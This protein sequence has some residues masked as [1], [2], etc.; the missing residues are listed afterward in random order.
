MAAAHYESSFAP[1]LPITK[2]HIALLADLSS[3]RIQQGPDAA[4]AKV[5]EIQVIIKEGDQLFQRRR[6]QP[7]LDSFKQARA[8]IY[9]MLYPGFNS[10]AYVFNNKDVLLPV[11]AATEK[12][13]MQLS[14]RM[15]DAVRPTAGLS[16]PDWQVQAEAAPDTLK[17]FFSTGFREAVSSDEILQNANA[18]AIGLFAESKPELALEVLQAA[19][20]R[21]EAD[22]QV[23]PSLAAA[24]RLN[25]AAAHLQ[26]D[27]PREAAAQAEAAARLYEQSGDRVGVA[28]ALHLQGV[29]AEKAGNPD[30]AR[31]LLGRAAEEMKQVG[32]SGSSAP[33]SG[34]TQPPLSRDIG[35]L[36]PIAELDTRQFSYRLPGRADG[37]GTLPFTDP[38]LKKQQAKSW[39]VGFQVG[40]EVPVF[41]ISAGQPFAVDA[42]TS[43]FYDKRI[44]AEAYK[45]LNWRP[46]DPPSTIPFITHLYAYALLVKIGDCQRELGQYSLA[47][48]TYLQAAGYSYLNKTIEATVL[49]LRL[50]T[51][52]LAWGDALYKEEDLPGAKLQYGKLVTEGGEVPNSVLYTTAALKAPADEARMLIASIQARPLPAVNWEIAFFVLMASSRLQQILQNLDFYGLA[53]SPIHTFEFLQSVARGFAQEAIQ[54]EREFVTFKNHQELEAATRRDLETVKAMAHAEADARL[55]Q[56]LAAKEDEAAAER[57]YGLALKRHDDAVAQRDAYA[58]SS[59]AQIWAQAAATALGGGEDAYWSE[60]SELADRLDRGETI[61]GPGP[62]LAAAQILRAGRKTRTYELEKMQDTIDQLTQA[63]AIA[64]DQWD[65]ARFR[66]NAAEIAWEAA[67]QRAEMA[68]ASLE[69]FDDEFFTP[70]AWGKMADVLRD[71]S[72]S[73]LFRAI[74]IAKLMERAYNFDNDTQIKIIKNDYGFT[75][76]NAAAGEDTRLLGGDTLLQDIESFTYHAITG[77]IRKSSRIKDVISVASDFPAQFEAFRETG[78]LE[79]ETDLYEFDRLHP[80]FYRQRLEA[81]EVELVGLLPAAGL[82]GTL[83]AGGATRFRQ[84]DGTLGQ[85]VHQV[86]TMALSDFVIRNDIFLYSTETGVRG[87]FQGLG[88]GSTWQLHLPKRSNDFDFRRIF[89]VNLVLY[90]TALYDAGLRGQVLAQPPR[91]GELEALRSFGLRYDFPDVWYAFYRTGT[92]SFL[93]DRFRLPFNQHNFAVTGAHFRIITKPGVA[94]H[95]ITLRITGPNGFAG[96]AVTDAA[97][98]V[99][100]EAASLA[101]LVGADPLGTW[102]VEVQGGAPLTEGGSLQLE[103]VYNIQFGLEYSFE[104][105]PEA[106]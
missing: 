57:A 67:K 74:R 59:N 89:D 102:E 105:V 58:A 97:G 16:E 92:A 35:E 84:K 25:L 27:A 72:R 10:E 99:S 48:A 42:L 18:R 75:I 30:L 17:P 88:V 81:V 106:L 103:R 21:A 83:T 19:I 32:G 66:S 41:A 38:L 76:G 68:D 46:I 95:D 80:G 86:D 56:Y 71:I 37:W 61:S 13:I 85:R 1:V 82:N 22:R 7:A 2:S 39:N 34:P 87:L 101:G 94:N 8:L 69:A 63:I 73:Y 100:S 5:A 12:Q 50:A 6:Y 26:I 20:K 43:Q 96:T 28:Q 60:I 4:Q 53:L 15:L 45:D 9:K 23:D 24:T 49:W 104:Y 79:F 55:Q 98:A 14:A 36:R 62:K 29:G 91:P 11:S 64:K 90:Y 3:I 47:E 33:P 51:N 70:D 77:K 31:Q 52:V 44:A 65:S 40:D 54:A 78:L 93:F